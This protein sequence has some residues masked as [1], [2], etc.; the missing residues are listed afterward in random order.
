MDP[1]GGKQLMHST[2]SKTAQ[3]HQTEIC[4]NR[5]IT[6]GPAHARARKI[7]QGLS[8]QLHLRSNESALCES[9]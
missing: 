9:Q 7:S 5:G 2:D 6:E 8:I 1:A 4:F 3:T